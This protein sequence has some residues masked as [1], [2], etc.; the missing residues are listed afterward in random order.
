M[1]LTEQI[2]VNFVR[3]A[4]PLNKLRMSRRLCP[5]CRTPYHTSDEEYV[6][7]IK[8]RAGCND[9]NAMHQLGCY[10]YTGDVGLP[11]DC[12]KAIEL[13]LRAGELGCA[14]SYYNLAVSYDNGEG[15][16]RDM[17]KASLYD[18]LAAM[19]GRVVARHNLGCMEGR[20]GN[21]DRAIKH[22]MISARAG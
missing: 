1:Q 5:F 18:E 13:W 16:E 8:K 4:E 2:A 7:R 15:V 12:N 3:F 14:E 19:G 10:Y 11:Q 9:A 21:L 17:K 22:L 6:K 20:A